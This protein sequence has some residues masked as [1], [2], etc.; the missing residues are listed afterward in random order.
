MR[1]PDGKNIG[2]VDKHPNRRDTTAQ[3]RPPCGKLLQCDDSSGHHG[4]TSNKSSQINALT[5]FYAIL[6]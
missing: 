6:T 3:D 1:A 4:I 5:G 2:I